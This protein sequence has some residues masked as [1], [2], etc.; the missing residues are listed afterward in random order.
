LLDIPR[1]IPYSGP[2]GTDPAL[3]SPSTRLSPQRFS[4][5][6]PGAGRRLRAAKTLNSFGVSME[7]FGLLLAVPLTFATSL[8]YTALIL[9]VF[10]FLPVVG[11]VL[12]AA[13]CFVVALVAVELL[14]LAA[15]G[16]RGTY[17][18]LGH[19][20]TVMHFL[21]FP[22]GPPAVANLVLHFASRWKLN[23]WLR[24]SSAMLCCWIA[25]MAA[26]LGH[27]IVDEAI[28]GIDAG[29]PFYMTPSGAPNKAAAPNRR[30]RFPLA[31][32][33]QFGYPFYAPPATPAAVGEPQR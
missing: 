32:V 24:F 11:R 26:L 4:S 31:D 16:A 5:I 7:L 30:P 8:V 12:V 15:M 14:L 21:G 20:F 27:I 29:K 17:A 10:R 18:H 9:A 28:V 6:P 23:K 22:L 13:S 19:A 1:K 33:A 3:K 2:T 25:C